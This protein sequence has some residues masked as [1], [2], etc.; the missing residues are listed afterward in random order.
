MNTGDDIV[1]EYQGADHAGEY[2]QKFGMGWSLVKIRPDPIM[3]YGRIGRHFK[4]V[5]VDITVCVR[6][7]RIHLA[8]GS[9]NG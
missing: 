9:T 6:D 7:S 1:V 2:L 5:G 8:K 4:N 3:D